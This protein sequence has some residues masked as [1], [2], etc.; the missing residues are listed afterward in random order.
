M[1]LSTEELIIL[2]YGVREDSWVPWTARRSKQSTLQEINPWCS[3][4][5]LIL[6]LKLQ[7]IGHLIGRADSFEKTLMLG[8]FE[9]RR[10]SGWQ[11]M[12]W[13]D[14]I[15][16]SMSKLLE[17]VWTVKPGVLRFMGLQRVGH[18]WIELKQYI[19][20][21]SADS[22][23]LV[24]LNAI[25]CTR[26]FTHIYLPSV[27]IGAVNDV[28]FYVQPEKWNEIAGCTHQFW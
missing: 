8:K 1:K 15:T 25:V 21:F 27:G 13:S 4:E 6:K 23:E 5:G 10:R 17:L 16:S 24:F 28:G 19:F 22:L 2:N 26:F 7:Y 18:D 14:G 9:S 12:R 11:Q 3:L 20:S